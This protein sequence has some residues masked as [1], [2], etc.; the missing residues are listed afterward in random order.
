MARI[1]ALSVAEQSV[2]PAAYVLK[3]DHCRI[4]RSD[5]CQII[6]QD[7]RKLV[8]RLHAE[9]EYQDMRYVL[10]DKSMNGTFVNGQRIHGSHYL[11]DKDL[12]GLGTAEASLQFR[13]P[14][15]TMPARTRLRYE[16][17]TMT[18]FIEQ[19][20]L[21]LPPAQF[22]L[23][24]HLYQHAH[25]VC[26]RESCA[27]AI[28]GREYDPALDTKALDQAI[29]KLRNIL[30][31]ADPSAAELLRTHRGQGYILLP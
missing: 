7:E 6:V 29:T 4:G 8:S 18:F 12:I 26:T 9:I 30:R 19:R 10:Y 16:E 24:S 28:W 11:E 13:D 25:T 5:E 1:I 27:E 3:T 15:S 14:E 20:P 22:R 31:D 23:L 2:V 17:R 21:E